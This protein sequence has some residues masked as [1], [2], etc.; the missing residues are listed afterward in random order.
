MYI[1][2]K[3][4]INYEI[5][6]YWLFPKLGIEVLWEQHLS[7]YREWRMKCRV[8]AKEHSSTKQKNRPY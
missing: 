3:L 7:G 6:I 1:L 2:N 4:N 8:N 5:I